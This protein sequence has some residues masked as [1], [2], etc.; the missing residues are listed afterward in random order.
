[1]RWEQD[2][3][4]FLKCAEPHESP[5]AGQKELDGFMAE[6]AELRRKYRMKN[7]WLVGTFA[8]KNPD[9]DRVFTGGWGE[10]SQ[11]LDL[12]GYAFGVAYGDRQKQLD[13]AMAIG[14]IDGRR[15]D[16]NVV[17]RSDG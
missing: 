8:C 17:G 14:E 2:K 5:E 6:V 4:N 15:D 13:V 3:E 7:V 10:Q 1:M 9:G 12:Y 11:C 16:D